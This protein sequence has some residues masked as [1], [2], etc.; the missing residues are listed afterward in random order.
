MLSPQEKLEALK[1]IGKMPEDNIFQG[2]LREAFLRNVK[3]NQ[4][5]PEWYWD[6]KSKKPY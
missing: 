2:E 4:S 3:E 6:W 5:Y 1:S